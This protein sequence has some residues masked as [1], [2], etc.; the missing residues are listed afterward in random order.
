MAYNRNVN[1]NK[2]TDEIDVTDNFRALFKFKYASTREKR[3]RPIFRII[4]NL[5]Q[6]YKEEEGREESLENI[7]TLPPPP[8]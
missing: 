5:K 8:C 1:Y 2:S 6:D 4:F 3:Y 7:Y